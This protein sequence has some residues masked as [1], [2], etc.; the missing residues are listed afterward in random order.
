MVDM[1]IALGAQ[2]KTRVQQE[3]MDVILFETRLANVRNLFPIFLFY[4]AR[5]H[6]L[7][8]VLILIESFQYS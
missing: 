4:H 6:L 8:H 3:M 2:N 7:I 5:M 1:A